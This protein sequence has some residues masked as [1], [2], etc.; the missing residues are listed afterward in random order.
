[1]GSNLRPADGRVD[2]SFTYSHQWVGR[3]GLCHAAQV[4]LLLLLVT[5]NDDWHLLKDS[6][7]HRRRLDVE[8]EEKRLTPSELASMAVPMP[9]SSRR[10]VNARPFKLKRIESP[11]LARASIGDLLGHDA[12]VQDA[13]AKAAVLLR[14]VAVDKANVVGLLD[15]GPRVLAG[16]V[17][18]RSNR[19]D[20]LLGELSRQ[21]LVLE[22]LLGELCQ[23]DMHALIRG[24]KTR[25][26]ANR[27]SLPKLRPRSEAAAEEERAEASRSLVLELA[28]FR[29][30]FARR[31]I[32]EGKGF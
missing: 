1:M 2:Q 15:D 28:K 20:L 25:G 19:Y 29:L 7:C 12:S 10:F 22:L 21:L 26:A 4:F 18:V 16:L 6:K 9:E 32:V 30:V 5:S 3:V 27:A 17:M 11:E 8:R 14:D 24:K 23:H 13:E 31:S